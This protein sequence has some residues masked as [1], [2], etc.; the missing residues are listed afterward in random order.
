M[1][2]RIWLLIL[3]KNSNVDWIQNLFLLMPRLKHFN[4]L[5]SNMLDCA[6]WKTKC[7]LQSIKLLLLLAFFIQPPYTVICHLVLFGIKMD[8][9]N[10]W[11]VIICYLFA[12]RT[13]I[14]VDKISM[15]MWRMACYSQNGPTEHFYHEISRMYVILCNSPSKLLWTCNLITRHY[16]WISF[17]DK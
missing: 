4:E 7:V 5:S 10:I 12:A 15:W 16:K 8:L 13:C 1:S 9:L 6:A 17:S 14:L 11:I 3:L 2:F